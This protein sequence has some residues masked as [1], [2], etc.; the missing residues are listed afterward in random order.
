MSKTVTF[1][2]TY[3]NTG[4]LVAP[5]LTT[6]I[7]DQ[8]PFP[9]PSGGTSYMPSSLNLSLSPGNHTIIFTFISLSEDLNNP[10]TVH[11]ESSTNVLCK[12][13]VK[14]QNIFVGGSIFVDNYTVPKTSPVNKVANYNLQVPVGAI[15]QDYE[16]YNRKWN[17]SGNNLSS[18]D[19]ER[20]GNGA[21]IFQSYSR[22]FNYTVLEDDKNKAIV[23]AG[24]RKNFKIDRVNQT[25]FDGNPTATSYIVEQN[26]GQISTFGNGYTPGSITYTF[27]GWT[28][29]LN[30]PTTRT[31]SPTENKTYSA[32]YKVTNK[33]NSTTAY[34]NPS[35]QK[36]IQTPDGVK[37]I[38]YES[39]NRVWL[40]HSTDNGVT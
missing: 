5:H 9:T 37:H 35:Q 8:Q 19:R 6:K 40:E 34:S 4:G 39:M 2:F 23:R 30:A 28:D 12:I 24:L 15:D 10:W 31:I 13:T 21:W 18:W 16:N 36:F 1:S 3:F 38:C 17:T 20:Y 32:L 11:Q 22:D 7:D 27:S 26:S 25:E 33:S 29:D 14:I